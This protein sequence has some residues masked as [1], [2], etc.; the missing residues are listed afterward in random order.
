[1]IPGLEGS[2][3]ITAL[4]MSRSKRYLAM[5]ES[6]DKCPIISVFDLH[7]LKTLGVGQKPKVKK[8]FASNEIKNKNFISIAF[9]QTNGEKMLVTLTDGDPD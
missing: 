8:L 2:E 3:R 6:T 1:M 4:A 9:S 7:Q 5:A